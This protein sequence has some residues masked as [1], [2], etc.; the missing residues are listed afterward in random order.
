MC[1]TID[2][3]YKMRT[4]FKY[5]IHSMA[6]ALLC[7]IFTVLV[8]G[9]VNKNSKTYRTLE[10]IQDKRIGFV[11]S[12]VTDRIAKEHFPNA[13]HIA[14]NEQMDAIAAL[15]AG[16]IDAAMVSYPTAFLVQK[17]VS[18]LVLIDEPVSNTQAGVGLKKDNIELLN[19]INACIDMLKQDG[20]LNDMIDRWYN[21]ETPNYKMPHIPLPVE[22]IPLVIGV[23]ADRE[24]SCFLAPRGDIIGFDSEL[25]YRI[26]KYMNRPIKFVDMKVASFASA[27]DSG[28]VDMVVSNFIIIDVLKEMIDFSQSYFDTPFMMIVNKRE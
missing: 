19:K 9:C 6:S 1:I 7:V 23:A 18:S 3:H 20:T 24:P 25:A 4:L 10:D 21:M 13:T 16:Q 17:N 28:K 5:K 2:N 15:Q 8:T 12:A 27:I 14:F 26:A 22:G 11:L